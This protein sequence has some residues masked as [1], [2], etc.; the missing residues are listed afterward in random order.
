MPASTAR[1]E[2]KRERML[3]A[4]VLEIARHGYFGTTVSSIASRAGVADGTIYLYFKSKEDVL[5]SIFQR[6]MQQFIGEAQRIVDDRAAG[7]E[8]KFRRTVAL[9]LSLLGE[10]RDL[11]VIFQVEF[12]H[13]LHVLELLSRSRIRDYLALI[14]RVVQQGKD[15]GVFRP[16]VDTL[17]AAKVV[18]GVLDEMATD[19]V[20]SRKNI[21]LASRAEPVSDL[22]LGGLR[23]S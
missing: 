13:T 5:V 6:A 11:A 4:A 21:R 8:E 17:L 23:I 16:E 1:K 12:R 10:N 15:E 2:A 3:D 7:A 19:W 22:L 20:L 18:F 14:A 9:H